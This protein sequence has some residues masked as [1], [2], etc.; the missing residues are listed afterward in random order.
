[1]TQIR[2]K[3]EILLPL[4]AIVLQFPGPPARGLFAISWLSYIGSRVSQLTPCTVHYRMCQNSQYTLSTRTHNQFKFHTVINLVNKTTYIGN[5]IKNSAT[6]FGSVEPSSGKVQ[7]TVLVP[8]A[9]AGTFI[10]VLYLVFSLMM[11]RVSRNMS[12]NF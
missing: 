10:P 11:V 5:N 8:S 1:M 6:C 3:A 12:P 4:P 9:S 7:D 2:W